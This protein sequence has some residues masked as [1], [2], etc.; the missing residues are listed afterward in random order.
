MSTRGTIAIKDSSGYVMG[1]YLHSDSYLE[2]AGEILLN[3]YNNLKKIS[4]LISNGSCSVL[5]ENIGEKHDFDDW[6]FFHQNHCC[7]FYHRD[8]GDRLQVIK[9]KSEQD[10]YDKYSESNDYLFK[11]GKWYVTTFELVNEKYNGIMIP[12]KEAIDIWK[13]EEE[14][15][16]KKHQELLQ[17]DEESTKRLA[18][19]VFEH[20]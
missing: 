19:K 8:R 16:Q 12:L 14:K 20:K 4:E 18:E 2:N 10:F 3:H 7:K 15:R 11:D 5:Y 1:I 17:K 6:Q 13:Q 9:A